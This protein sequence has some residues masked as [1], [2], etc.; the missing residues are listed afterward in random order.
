MI[1]TESIIDA[2]SLMVIGF[3]NV[4]ALLNGLNDAHMEALRESGTREV[5]LP[6]ITMM[7]GGR[8]PPG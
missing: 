7:Q 3:Q 5:V 4:D 1:L 2:L 6:L 8:G